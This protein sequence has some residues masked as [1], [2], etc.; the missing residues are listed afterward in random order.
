MYPRYM[1]RA[2]WRRLFTW[3]NQGPVGCSGFQKPALPNRIQIENGVFRNL[4]MCFS[5]TR[6]KL[7]A[8]EGPNKVGL[9]FRL[10]TTVFIKLVLH[11][12]KLHS[13]NNDAGIATGS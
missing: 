2:K 3:S 1:A 13:A 7:D 4:T 12:Q 6:L 5:G 9:S 10:Q 8:T 11:H